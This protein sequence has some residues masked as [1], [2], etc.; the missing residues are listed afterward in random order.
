MESTRARDTLAVSSTTSTFATCVLILITELGRSK[1][2][3]SA[4]FIR[5]S[6]TPDTTRSFV[7]AVRLKYATE[8]VDRRDALAADLQTEIEIS[9]KTV[10]EVGFD[11]IRS[12]LK[13]LN[14]LKIV[15][16]DMMRI[17]SATKDDHKIE[18]IC[19]SIV[20]LDVSRNLFK[21]CGDVVDLARPLANLKSLTLK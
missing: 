13:Q 15:L 11:K 17:D 14:E 18:D 8:T 1:S 12:Q 5:P 6:R 16:V 20:E 2:R 4:S 3:T 10:Y 7:E 21:D 9:G 19:P